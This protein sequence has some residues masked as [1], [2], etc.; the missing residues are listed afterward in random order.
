MKTLNLALVVALALGASAFAGEL[1]N[2]TASAAKTAKKKVHLAKGL[3]A[4]TIVRVSKDDPTQVEVAYLRDQ[5]P[6]GQKL[7]NL[8]FEKMAINAEVAGIPYTL[9]NELDVTSSTSSWFFGWNGYNRYLNYGYYGGW[10]NPS[11]FGYGTA[12]YYNRWA[13]PTYNYY[14]YNYYYAPYWGY[15]SRYYNYVYCNW[16]Y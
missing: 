12:Y 13:Y 14:G 4:T 9:K 11:Y 1:D 15:S 7:K 8:K 10:Y 6:A 5:V 3:P 16:Y 2:E